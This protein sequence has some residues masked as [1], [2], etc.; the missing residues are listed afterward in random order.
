MPKKQM[1]WLPNQLVEFK[2]F[3]HI[4]LTVYKSV[5]TYQVSKQTNLSRLLITSHDSPKSV[6]I[7]KIRVNFYRTIPHNIWSFYTMNL[8]LKLD[9]RYFVT[10]VGVRV[11]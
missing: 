8:H 6:V 11:D 3:V 10:L 4:H 9:P 1:I 7:D 2:Y 5:E